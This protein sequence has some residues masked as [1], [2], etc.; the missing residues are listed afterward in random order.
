MPS[1]PVPVSPQPDGDG[2]DVTLPVGAGGFQPGAVLPAAADAH[3][4]P[5]LAQR[6]G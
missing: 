4:R 3:R 2:A 1:P 5:T 6:G